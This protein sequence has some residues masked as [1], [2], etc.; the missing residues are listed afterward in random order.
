MGV[1]SKETQDNTRHFPL[2]QKAYHQRTGENMSMICEN[3]YQI[4][5]YFSKHNHMQFICFP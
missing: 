1:V 4:K 2:S 5:N 3:K